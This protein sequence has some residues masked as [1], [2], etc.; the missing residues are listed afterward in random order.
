MPTPIGERRERI[1]IEQSV[2]VSDGQGG[3]TQ[4]WGLR[5]VVCAREETLTSREAVMAKSLTA[6]LM[7]AW[8]IPFRSDISITDRI[9][10]GSRVLR[11]TSYQDVEGRHAE[12]RILA[13]ETQT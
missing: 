2:L 11:V 1:R 8:T 12:L 7:S 13:S 6:V 5:A 3:K 4:A 10:L 9:L